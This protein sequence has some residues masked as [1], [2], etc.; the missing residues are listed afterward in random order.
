[1]A[2]ADSWLFTA[3]GGMMM[4]GG[5]GTRKAYS[6]LLARRNERLVSERATSSVVDMVAGRLSEVWD[7]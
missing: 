7:E 2:L 5:V 3:G 1:M 4:R 6:L